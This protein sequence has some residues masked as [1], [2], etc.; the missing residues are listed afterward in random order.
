MH[1]A[2]NNR[3]TFTQGAGVTSR[4]LMMKYAYQEIFMMESA[5]MFL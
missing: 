5:N 2:W 3:I 1:V 4:D